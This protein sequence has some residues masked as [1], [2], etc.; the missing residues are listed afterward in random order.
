VAG[1]VFAKTIWVLLNDA[2]ELVAVLEQCCGEHVSDA[3]WSLFFGVLTEQ[4]QDKAAHQLW[5]ASN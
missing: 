3:D 4:S 2:D 5:A 1:V